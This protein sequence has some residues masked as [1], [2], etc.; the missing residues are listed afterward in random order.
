M[1]ANSEVVEKSKAISNHCH[2]FF[3]NATQA[4]NIL[5]LFKILIKTL[6][7]PQFERRLVYFPFLHAYH[8]WQQQ[9]AI[10]VLV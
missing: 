5:I 10:L 4:I 1:S 9:D 3:T 7:N 6:P 8:Q 2:L